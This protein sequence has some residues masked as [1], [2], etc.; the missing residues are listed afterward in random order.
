LVVAAQPPRTASANDVSLRDEH[1]PLGVS[2]V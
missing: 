2:A 1:T